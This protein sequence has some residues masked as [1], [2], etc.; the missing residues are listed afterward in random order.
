MY[1]DSVPPQRKKELVSTSFGLMRVFNRHLAIRV[2]SLLQ[3]H[4][5]VYGH[6]GVK[7]TNYEYLCVLL[8]HDLSW[9]E[10]VQS[11]CAKA[12]LGLLYRRFQ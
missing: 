5:D 12:I 2:V 7:I 10:H 3:V 6:Y 8:S 9:G 11:I 4:K 1:V